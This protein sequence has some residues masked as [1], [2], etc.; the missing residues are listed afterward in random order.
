MAASLLSIMEDSQEIEIDEAKLRFICSKYSIW[1]HYGITRD[2]YVRLGEAQ[3]LQM[4]KGFYKSKLPYTLVRVS[5]LF[6]ATIVCL[7]MTVESNTVLIAS[8]TL[9]TAAVLLTM[10][11]LFLLTKD[12]Y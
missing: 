7:L 9:F 8:L 12:L 4:L 6:A 10:K 5:C 11:K 2:H 3:K 1:D